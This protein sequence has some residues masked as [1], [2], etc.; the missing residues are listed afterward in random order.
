[1]AIPPFA[2]TWEDSTGIN[3]D[4]VPAWLPDLSNIP[5]VAVASCDSVTVAESPYRAQNSALWKTVSVG[6]TVS[7]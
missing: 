2:P 7:A 3:D 4:T 6:E 5:T 1:M